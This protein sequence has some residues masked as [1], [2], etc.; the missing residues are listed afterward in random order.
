MNIKY[1]SIIN[2][3][4]IHWICLLVHYFI[5]KINSGSLCFLPGVSGNVSIPDYKDDDDD[6]HAEFVE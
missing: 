1:K 3:L 6:N 4:L 2:N 5:K